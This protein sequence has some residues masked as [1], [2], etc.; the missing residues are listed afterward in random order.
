M[1]HLKDKLC[2]LKQRSDRQLTCLTYKRSRQPEQHPQVQTS[3]TVTRSNEKIKF[4]IPRPLLE[5]FK[6]FPLYRGGTLWDNLPAA[7]QLMT[8]YESFKKQTTEVP[9]L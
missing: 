5:K 9:K 6:A 4:M 8:D 7:T 3:S 2:P 1:L